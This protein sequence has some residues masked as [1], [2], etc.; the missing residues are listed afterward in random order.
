VLELF[1]ILRHVQFEDL[2]NGNFADPIDSLLRAI[3]PDATLRCRVAIAA[4]PATAR[5]GWWAKQ[6]VKRL[7][8]PF[9]R[10]HEVLADWYAH[11]ITR[12]RTWTVAWLVERLRQ[13]SVP[14]AR[15]R[16]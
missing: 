16:L 4:A 14:D 2:L 6:A 9:F 13:S 12:P 10:S 5:R 3:K 15:R 7:D 8:R 1:P 11:H